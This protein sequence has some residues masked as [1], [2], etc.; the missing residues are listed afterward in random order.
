MSDMMKQRAAVEFCFLL[1]ETAADTLVNLL[2][3][4][5]NTLT[6]SQ[7]YRGVFPLQISFWTTLTLLSNE[8]IRKVRA[9]FTPSFVGKGGGGGGDENILESKMCCGCVR[10]FISGSARNEE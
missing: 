1:G 8:N 2:T 4:Y 9:L 6:K 7:V 3:A 5:K 10:S